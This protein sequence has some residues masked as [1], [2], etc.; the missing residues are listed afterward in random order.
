MAPTRVERSE[1]PSSL[2][3]IL[4]D[5]SVLSCIPLWDTWAIVLA[6]VHDQRLSFPRSW[7][8]MFFPPVPARCCCLLKH[9]RSLRNFDIKACVFPVQGLD[10]QSTFEAIQGLFVSVTDERDKGQTSLKKALGEVNFC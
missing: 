4:G 5:V 3:L 2:Y 10:V 6:P 9:Q 7:C 8:L 1:G